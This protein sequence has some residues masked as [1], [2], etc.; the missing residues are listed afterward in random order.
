MDHQSVL[1]LPAE[2]VAI[3]VPIDHQIVERFVRHDP[4]F[5]DACRRFKS[6]GSRQGGV[7]V[8]RT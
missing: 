8:E 2:Q 1:I 3:A 7:V 6:D 5:R 4:A